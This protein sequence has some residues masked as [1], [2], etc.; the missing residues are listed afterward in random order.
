LAG[1]VFFLSPLFVLAGVALASTGGG[2]P[3]PDDEADAT[4]AGEG[5]LA[6]ARP[7][8]GGFFSASFAAF[9][10]DGVVIADGAETAAGSAVAAC[11][12]AFD[13]LR[14]LPLPLDAVLGTGVEWTGGGLAACGVA[15]ADDLDA[16]FR[17]VANPF[18]VVFFFPPAGAPV[19]AGGAGAGVAGTEAGPACAGVAAAEG[20]AE[21]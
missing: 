11:T 8:L 2:N 3:V 1:S 6:L 4:A 5:S 12:G 18:F 9:A 20:T 13:C 14:L 19:G 7:F 15:A 17:G 10:L 21:G 16:L